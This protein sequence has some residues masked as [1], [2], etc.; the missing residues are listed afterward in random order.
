M[1]TRNGF[2]SN[3]NSASFICYWRYLGR[4]GGE[5]L[6]LQDSIYKLFDCVDYGNGCIGQCPSADELI[7]YSKET[8][9]PGTFVTE[10]FTSMFNDITDIPTSFALLVTGLKLGNGFELIDLR[11]YCD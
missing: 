6:S 1:K 8:S 7:K 5:Q 11:V 4:G 3:S 9:S 2:V 10:M